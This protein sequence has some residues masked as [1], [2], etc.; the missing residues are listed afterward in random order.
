MIS[1][2]R[3][4]MR[5]SLKILKPKP[6]SFTAGPDRTAAKDISRKGIPQREAA[7]ALLPPIQGS[8]PNY[9]PCCGTS[10]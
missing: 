1:M 5:L 4:S 9:L 8:D 3:I 7:Q 10:L 2:R 6:Q